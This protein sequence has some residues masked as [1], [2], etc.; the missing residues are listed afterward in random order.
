ME[1]QIVIFLPT[2]K[3]GGTEKRFLRLWIYFQEEDYTNIKLIINQNLYEEVIQ[4]EE[5]KSITRYNVIIIPNKRFRYL[6]PYLI[7]LFKTFP[8]DT[9]FHCPLGYVPFVHTILRQKVIVTFPSAEFNKVSMGV[10]NVMVLFDCL[11]S[12]WEAWKIDVLSPVARDQIKKIPFVNSKKVFLTPGSFVD[13][14][15]YCPSKAK[16]NWLVFLGRF[17]YYDNK[18]VIRFVKSIPYMFNYFRKNGIKDVKFFILGFG[19]KEEEV[20]AVLR[21]SEYHSIP[22]ECYFESNPQGILSKSKV[23]FSL[24]KDSNYPSK[25]LLEALS[26]GNLSVVTDVGETRSIAKESFAFFVNAHFAEE[27]LAVCALRILKMKETEFWMR[28]DESIN[29]IKE[30]FS[31]EKM[32]EYYLRLYEIIPQP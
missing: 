28:V 32:E 29:F 20:K 19:V 1:K 10:S 18:N 27:D 23:F 13:V 25:S 4:I 15:I 26:C 22:I 5:L 8:K 24:Q 21:S 7:N 11:I 14:N 16:K 31:I 17:N 3:I 30:N 2:P 12:F 9:I 6:I